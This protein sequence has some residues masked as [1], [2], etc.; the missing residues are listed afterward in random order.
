VSRNTTSRVAG[1]LGNRVHHVLYNFVIISLAS[2]PMSGL[3]SGPIPGPLVAHFLFL[4]E[5]I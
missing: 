1:L 2:G 5:I 4:Y 3:L